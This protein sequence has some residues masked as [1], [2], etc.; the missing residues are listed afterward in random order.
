MQRIFFVFFFET[1]F[2]R[3]FQ[4]IN[5]NKYKKY[6]NMINKLYNQKYLLLNNKIII[7]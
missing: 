5:L 6:L 2:L 7:K 3:P 1:N 4:Y